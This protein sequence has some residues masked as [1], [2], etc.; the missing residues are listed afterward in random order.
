MRRPPP[1]FCSTTGPW[2]SPDPLELGGGPVLDHESSTSNSVT[3][4]LKVIVMVNGSLTGGSASVVISG[5]GSLDH[6]SL[7]P[8]DPRT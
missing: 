6:V 5:T 4:T 1:P 8:Q 2:V 3:G 7:Q